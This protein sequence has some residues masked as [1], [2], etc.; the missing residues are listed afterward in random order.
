MYDVI[1]WETNNYNIHIPNISRS[2]CYQERKFGQLTEYNMRNTIL[3]KSYTTRGGET[4]PTLFFQK[5]I[6]TYLWIN[7][8]KF[9]TVSFYCTSE[10][11]TIKIYLN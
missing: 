8:W 6:W 9:Y 1:Y 10:L 4:S 2:K 5:L 3:E 7:I 11:K